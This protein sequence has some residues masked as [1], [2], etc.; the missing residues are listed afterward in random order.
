MTH[1][2]VLFGAS[3]DL[4]S[5]KL[6]P[7]LARLHEVGM[8]TPDFAV[9]AIA[10]D[11]WGRHRL[12]ESLERHAGDVG[13]QSRDALLSMV[14]YRRADVT[15]RA[16]VAEALQPN[17]QPIIAYLAL[18]PRIF[19]PSI[20]ALSGAGLPQGSRVVIEKPFGEGLA[21]AQELNR[22]LHRSFPENAV[23]RV[24]HFLHLQTVQNVLGLRF[25]N[26][27]FERL[28]NRDHIERVEIIWDE[29]L[30]L[31]GRA[32][33]YDQAGAL[34]DMIQNHLLQ[35]LCL[36]GMEAPLTL[37]ERDVRDRKVDV[38][39]A[40]RRLSPQEVE[41]HTVRA[42]YTAGL[43]GQREVPSYTDEK[44]ID[45]ARA[46]ETFAQ[47]TLWLDNLRWAGVPFVLRSGKA[48]SR[49][50]H[51]IAV[52]FRPMPHLAFEA[53]EP[54]PNVLRLLLEPDRVI[55]GLNLNCPGTPFALERVDLA[56]DRTS[57]V[58]PAY[59]RLLL[60]I[61]EGDSTLSIRDDE[62]EESWRVV[63]PILDA[64]AR[65]R[66]PLREYPAG[67]AGPGQDARRA[68]EGREE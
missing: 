55:F 63:E 64:W 62:A 51:E 7:A 1:R 36:V 25:A 17:R 68:G 58:L 28:W 6:M 44:G 33:Y 9:L 26:R 50:R 53:N 37:G 67:S 60:H 24:D 14:E 23:F 42:R 49:E 10:R 16:Q 41:H 40:I 29:S 65:G 66:S 31:E 34:K 54:P 5:R 19:L 22:L 8:L 43:I 35:L 15:D 12:R 32:S 27:V 11:D 52:H 61:L 39:R 3:G 21:Q 4:T 13:L 18:P 38:L 47:V 2:L 20:E 45:P 46:T 56:A 48:L 57:G 59:A 30:T